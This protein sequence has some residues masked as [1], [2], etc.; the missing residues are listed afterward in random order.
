M[1]ITCSVASGLWLTQQLHWL[2]QSQ[3]LR[4]SYRAYTS[5][6]KLIWYRQ[7]L[8]IFYD[9]C[10]VAKLNLSTNWQAC[11]ASS[12]SACQYFITNGFIIS[13]S[14]KFK[15][16]CHFDK[17]YSTIKKNSSPIARGRFGIWKAKD[18]ALLI[19]IISFLWI[20]H[21]C[22]FEVLH[23]WTIIINGS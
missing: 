8:M 23:E 17:T 21:I 11:F 9:L 2:T 14:L 15:S 12:S 18:C 19:R 1:I 13:R 5:R 6:S 16:Y 7:V 10:N 22:M 20:Y 4:L 3:Y